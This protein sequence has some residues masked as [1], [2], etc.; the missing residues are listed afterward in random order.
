[1]IGRIM[2][3]IEIESSSYVSSSNESGLDRITGLDFDTG[4]RHIIAPAMFGVIVG[5]A[6]QQYITPEYNWPSPPQGAILCSILLSPLLYFTLVRDEPSRWYEYSMGLALPGTIFFMV[7]FSGWGA[8]FC[9][10]YGALLL[11][12]WIS[13]SWG[14]YDLPPFRYGVWHAFA[15]D[16]GSFS[17]AL[18][19]YSISL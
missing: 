2:D 9:S 4:L 7:W 11:W 8:L 6:F 5:I 12:V 18:L 10:G 14:R 13:T 17:G 16:I 1:M 15:V 3:E 19:A